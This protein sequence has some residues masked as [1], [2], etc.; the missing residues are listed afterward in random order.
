[1]IQQEEVQT[2]GEMLRNARLKRGITIAEVANELCIRKSY[3]T[4]IEDMD[5]ANIPPVPYGVGFI[6]SYAQFLGL[7]SDRII[8]SY[9]QF[10]TEENGGKKTPN[11]E[12]VETSK[13]H[14]KHIFLGLCGLAALFIAWSVMP[15]SEQVEEFREDAASVVATPVIVENDADAELISQLQ[16]E[17][18]KDGETIIADETTEAEDAEADE[19]E[20]NETTEETASEAEEVDKTS[21][22]IVVSGPTWLELKQDKT[23]LLVGRVYDNGFEYVVPNEKGLRVTVGR[24]HNVKFMVGDEEKPVVSVMKRKNVSLDEFMPQAEQE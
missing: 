22:K 9:R 14:F 7:N 1:E 2:V 13:P 21:M 16:A 12:S 3:V 8:S 4:A 19:I 10:M 24:P 17:D 11:E 5:Y 6:R 20:E 15:L 18:E 23:V